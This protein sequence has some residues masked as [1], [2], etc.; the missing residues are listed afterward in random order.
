MAPAIPAGS[1]ILVDRSRT[2]RRDGLIFVV[3][4]SA[5]MVVKRAERGK[6]GGWQLESDHPAWGPT[7]YPEDAVIL[8]RVVWTGRA[9]V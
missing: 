9:L 6:G 7:A 2:Q 4:T 3:R 5:G 8:G 1:S